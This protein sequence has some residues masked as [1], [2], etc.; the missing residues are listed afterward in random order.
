MT[1]KSSSLSLSSSIDSRAVQSTSWWG[2]VEK[3]M[4]TR[5]ESTAGEGG[6]G[7]GQG[8]EVDRRREWVKVEELLVVA[9]VKVEGEEQQV[10]WLDIRAAI[11]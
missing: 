11:K 4:S 6:G 8:Q 3:T 9:V 7:G 10:D 2:G 1:W 5:V